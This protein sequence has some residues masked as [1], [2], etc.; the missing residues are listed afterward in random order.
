M[1]ADHAHILTTAVS[2]AQ[3]VAA[4]DPDAS[5]V[6]KITE[7]SPGARIISDPLA[8]ISDRN[9]DAVLIASPDDTHASLVLACLDAGKPVLCE[10]PLAPSVEDCIRVLEKETALQ[11][12]LVTVGYMRRFD[13]GYVEM[14]RRLDAGELGAA[15]ILHCIHRNQTTTPFFTGPM[16]ITNSAVHEFDIARFVLGQNIRRIS[17]VFPRKTSLS[18]MQDPQILLLEMDN[19]VLVDVEIFLNSQYG[20]DVRAELVC[21]RGTITLTP[22]HDVT[23]L[24]AAKQGFA[25]PSDWRPRFAAAYRAELQAWVRAIDQGK[26]AGA[27]AW[28]GYVATAVAQA[29]LQALASG[30]STEVNLIPR[31]SLYDS[32]Q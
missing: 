14:K 6:R 32:C 1:G 15:L 3:L 27:S 26:H 28:D 31:P 9:V 10:K 20:Y 25:L 30:E 8:L 4:S 17:V 21:E 18:A 24:Q 13:P 12:Q 5:R 7:L 19:G 23:T 22:P 11:R 29:G 2:G 16:L